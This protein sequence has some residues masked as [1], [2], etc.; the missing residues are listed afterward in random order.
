MSED[1]SRNLRIVIAGFFFLFVGFDGAQQY[2]VPELAA[3]G[4]E[5]LALNALIVLYAV[6]FGASFFA[7]PLIQR[8]GLKRSLVCAAASYAL[9]P[10][11]VCTESPTAL[12]VGSTLVGC[13]AAFLW[14]AGGQI[15]KDISPA[16]QLSRNGS[17]Q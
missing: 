17:L 15:I 9:F 7:P 4:E 10:F 1:S 2:L 13:S 6:F 8:L 12:Y 5:A 3:R 14:N 11:L 16:D